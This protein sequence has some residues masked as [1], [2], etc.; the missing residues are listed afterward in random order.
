MGSNQSARRKS[1]GQ[2]TPVGGGVVPCYDYSRTTSNPI[3][4]TSKRFGRRAKVRR[5]ISDKF[6]ILTNSSL[7]RNEWELA[8][9]KRAVSTASD[10]GHE[11]IIN[12]DEIS[13]CKNET[14]NEHGTNYPYQPYSLQ[15]WKMIDEE[16]NDNSLEKLLLI[17]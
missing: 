7:V 15:N 6:V 2:C 10:V 12:K 4:S 8:A 14:T 3:T 1:V 16:G 11:S 17:N 13:D 9:S 5:S